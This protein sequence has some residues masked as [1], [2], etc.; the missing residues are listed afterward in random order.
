MIRFRCDC[1]SSLKAADKL[2][3]K[4]SRCPGCGAVVIVPQAALV[5]AGH[6]SPE[7]CPPDDAFAAPAPSTWVPC[8]QES[9]DPNYVPTIIRMR[10]SGTR[11]DPFMGVK[12]VVF[13]SG[14]LALL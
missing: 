4:S 14:M 1:G 3:E 12:F 10:D 13:L 8:P 11:P 7:D 2:A 9:G 6:E 5:F